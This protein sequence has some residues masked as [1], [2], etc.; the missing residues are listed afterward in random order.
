MID[1]L[2]GALSGALVWAKAL[3][4]AAVAIWI[5]GL[6]ALPGLCR[7]R[8]ATAEGPDLHRLQR[9]VR[10]VY[11]AVI[12]PAAF[13]AVGSGTA[14]IFLAGTF[15]PWFALKLGL[16]GGLAGLHLLAGLVILRLFEAGETYGRAPAATATALTGALALAVLGVVLA[17]P[18]LPD[19][20]PAALSRPGALQ[21][22]AAPFNPYR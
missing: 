20:A 22:L 7:R 15:A 8:A 12:S 10:F 16:V 21:D 1:A 19:L 5:S 14:L 6:I 13:V 2:S 9:A 4:I 18:A 3:H 11:V 17:K